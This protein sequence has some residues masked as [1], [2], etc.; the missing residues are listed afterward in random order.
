[1][2]ATSSGLRTQTVEAYLNITVTRNENGPI[3][4]LLPYEDRIE[5]TVTLSESVFKVT[6]TDADGV[7]ERFQ[8][9]KICILKCFD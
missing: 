3:F 1:M 4:Q 5:D 2:K 7:S 9:I 8:L 6:A